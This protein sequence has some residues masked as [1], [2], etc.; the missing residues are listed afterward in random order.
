MADNLDR[1]AAPPVFV[2][3]CERSGTTL[4]FE[5]LESH[6]EVGG[7]FESWLFNASVGIAGLFDDAV[8]DAERVAL[9]RE[10]I[11]RPVGVRALVTR[12]ELVA[13]L[14]ALV[15]PWLAHALEPGDRFLVEKSPV[16]IFTAPL[17]AEVLPGAR[18]VE[19]VRDGRDV[20]LSSLASNQ[21]WGA[22]VRRDPSAMRLSDAARMWRQNVLAGRR[23][24]RSLP[25]QWLRVRFEDLRSDFAG[26]LE[27][28]FGFCEIPC[29]EAIIERARRATALDGNRI[30]ETG[31]RRGGKVSGW[32][33]RLGAHGALT[34]QRIAGDALV[35]AGY[36]ANGRWVLRAARPR[37]LR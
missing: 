9:Q 30:S 33:A 29:D 32:R 7:V 12:D 27:R 31:F 16:H 22:R 35:R 1:L 2:V 25:G 19:I 3:G 20:A 26:T 15:V 23:H 11:G 18:F 5:A 34:F 6:P 14:H 28:V 24:E 37:L 21:G 36:E 10:H 17:I 13:D 8:W 4:L